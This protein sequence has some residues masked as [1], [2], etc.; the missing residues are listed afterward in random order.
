MQVGTIDLIPAQQD[1]SEICVTDRAVA[2]KSSISLSFGTCECLFKTGNSL[3]A[4]HLQV[5]G[6]TG[7]YPEQE[8]M[9]WGI[10]DISK[11][12]IFECVIQV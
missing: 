4:R 5:V 2:L 3:I 12:L 6:N 1:I 11:F 7:V 10:V 9:T 8:C